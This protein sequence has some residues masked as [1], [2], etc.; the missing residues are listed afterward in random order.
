[1]FYECAS[2]INGLIRHNNLTVTLL[3]IHGL[4]R[5]DFKVRGLRF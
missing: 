3:R 2:V 5:K 1:M 4:I